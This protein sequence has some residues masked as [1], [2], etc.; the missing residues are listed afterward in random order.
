MIKLIDVHKWIKNRQSSSIDFD[1]NIEEIN[2]YLFERLNKTVPLDNE[3]MILAA[4]DKKIYGFV[5]M[6]VDSI[7]FVAVERA[8]Y[9]VLKVNAI[10]IDKNY[11]NSGFG[12]QLLL[13]CYRLALNLNDVVPIDGIYLVALRDAIDFMKNL[14]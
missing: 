14:I 1:C 8:S 7:K 5:S 3:R 6:S 11:Q 4:D 2:N 9:P 10:G 13:S 12:T